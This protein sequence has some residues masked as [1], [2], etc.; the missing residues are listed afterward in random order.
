MHTQIGTRAGGT[1]VGDAMTYTDI[2]S[3]RRPV[4]GAGVWDVR[5]ASVASV[6]WQTRRGKCGPELYSPL[7]CF[8]QSSVHSVTT[9][10]THSTPLN[11]GVKEGVF[12][13]S[14]SQT[15]LDL[16]E[17]HRMLQSVSTGGARLH[18]S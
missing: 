16:G 4:E 7:N 12:T 17:C 5:V 10:S 2:V 3:R 13:V 18:N 14:S 6:A 15:T 9:H 8:I 11:Q 1:Y